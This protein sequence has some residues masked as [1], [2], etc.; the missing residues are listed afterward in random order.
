MSDNVAGNVITKSQITRYGN[1]QIDTAGTTDTGQDDRSGPEGAVILDLIEN[2][3]HVLV[4][5]IGKD[6]D[7]ETG[8][9]RNDALIRDDADIALE[10]HVVAFCKVIDDQHDEIANGYESDDASILERI[11]SAEEGER[12]NDKPGYWSAGHGEE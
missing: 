10:T 12:D 5:G 3:E 9:N 6:D 2:R 11:K 4:T 8:K 1:E 7:G